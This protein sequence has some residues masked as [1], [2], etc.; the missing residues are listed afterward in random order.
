MNKTT[1]ANKVSTALRPAKPSAVFVKVF[2]QH[3]FN[4]SLRHPM[5]KNKG[6]STAHMRNDEGKKAKVMVV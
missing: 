1:T 2:E 4:D 5:H 6:R 3:S